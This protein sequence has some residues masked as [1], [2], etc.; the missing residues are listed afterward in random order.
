[1][2][3]PRL[4]GLFAIIPATVLL[5]ISFFVLFTLRAIKENAL[6]VF[7][8]VIVALLWAAALL[9]FSSGIYTVSTGKC[10][11][12][13]MMQQMMKMHMQ[14]MMQ[15][16]ESSSMMQKHTGESMMKH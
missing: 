13:P 3:M 12:K 6:K 16:G 11:M 15:P 9:V 5:T 7:G 4:I 2:G 8:Y 1:M 14:E 10:L